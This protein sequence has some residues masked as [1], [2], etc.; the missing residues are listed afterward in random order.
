MRRIEASLVTWPGRNSESRIISAFCS[1]VRTRTVVSAYAAGRNSGDDGFQVGHLL[2]NPL[3]D[4]LQ[5]FKF[6][7]TLTKLMRIWFLLKRSG[8]THNSEIITLD[9]PHETGL[10]WTYF[11]IFQSLQDCYWWLLYCKIGIYPTISSTS[12]ADHHNRSISSILTWI[13][14]GR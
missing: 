4:G 13:R 7:I 2:T 14:P 10:Y 3:R 11:I 8:L 1:R 12:P 6:F 9:A 5:S